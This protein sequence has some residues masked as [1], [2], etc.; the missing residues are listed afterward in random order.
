[1]A[2][3][4]RPLLAARSDRPSVTV[5]PEI[6]A[7]APPWTSK[8]VH[9]SSPLTVTFLAPGPLILTLVATWSEPLV[10]LMVP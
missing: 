6:V 2:I 10:R 8:T 1:M 5:R 3:Q 7:V 4:P 9:W